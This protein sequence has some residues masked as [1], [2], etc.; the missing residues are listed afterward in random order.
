MQ[1]TK[2]FEPTDAL[3]Q[4]NDGLNDLNA[5]DVRGD[6]W[7]W[8]QEQNLED[9]ASWYTSLLF[10]SVTKASILYQIDLSEFFLTFSPIKIRLWMIR[11]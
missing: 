7:E 5:H 3:N 6:E 8:Y 4:I 1:L 9:T 10:S 11:I 2:A